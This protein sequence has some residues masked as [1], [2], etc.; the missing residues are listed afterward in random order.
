MSFNLNRAFERLFAPSTN[1]LKNQR[2]TQLKSW[3]TTKNIRWRK[4]QRRLASSESVGFSPTLFP[5]HKD[6]SDTSETSTLTFFRPRYKKI[7]DSW[8]RLIS[9]LFQSYLL[10]GVQKHRKSS[11]LVISL[12]IFLFMFLRNKNLL[13]SIFFFSGVHHGWI[14]SEPTSEYYVTFTDRKIWV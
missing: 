10:V 5:T 11:Y 4:L 2:E 14:L 3:R 12:V 9:L 13:N 7:R 6:R 1:H 8:P